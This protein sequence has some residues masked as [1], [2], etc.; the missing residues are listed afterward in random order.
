ME[1]R[2]KAKVVIPVYRP[3][4]AAGE[5]ASLRNTLDKLGQWP[6]V[7]LKPR[8]LDI[9]AVTDGL[10][11]HEELEVS[12][13]WLGSRNGIHGY[14]VMMLSRGFYELFADTD[15]ILVC[16]TDA[17]IFRDELEM[18]CD[19]GYDCVAAPWIRRR[20]YDLPLVK[21]YMRFRY[22]MAKRPGELLK[23]D[24]YGRIGNGGLT[25]RRVDSFIGACDRYA[26]ETERFKSGRGHL[27]NEDV[28]WAT[29]P[30]GFRYP[31][32]E[33]ALAFAFDT[34]PRYCYRLCGGCLP[35]GCHSWN[36][37][38]MWRFWR[39]IISF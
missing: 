35:F 39:N 28:F 24:I 37:P 25:L 2:Y 16:H 33:E 14:N 9:S 38:R 34:N 8:G 29:V 7:L 32:P 22:R 19:R 1:K 31:T 26:A 4:L 11:P 5:Q 36:K 21:Q 6:I 10:P 27:W 18:W 3:S 30:A 17:W 23:Q 15:Y 13:E 20:V 12:D